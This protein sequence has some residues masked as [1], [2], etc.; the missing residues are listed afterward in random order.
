MIKKKPLTAEE[1][2]EFEIM[3]RAARRCDGN[4]FRMNL[5]LSSIGYF[6]FSNR[7]DAAQVARKEL[8]RKFVKY[9]RRE[10]GGKGGRTPLQYFKDLRAKLER[11]YNVLCSF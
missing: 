11:N 6:P 9:D 5:Y 3:K 1:I 8:M 2:V 10:N 4:A 7:S